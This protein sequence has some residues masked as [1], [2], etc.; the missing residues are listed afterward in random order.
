MTPPCQFTEGT[1]ATTP[2]STERPRAEERGGDSADFVHVHSVENVY[3]PTVDQGSTT[4]TTV[5]PSFTREH[6]RASDLWP[7][8]R[9]GRSGT[10]RTANTGEAACGVW[11]SCA[12]GCTFRHRTRTPRPAR[13][14]GQTGPSAVG[15]GCSRLRAEFL[16]GA[17]L[18]EILDPT[19]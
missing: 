6:T 17:K 16:A 11:D 19:L 1:G 10:R 2:P 8:C 5:R 13:G 4:L 9:I 7:E 14:E 12:S 3:S 18:R 15:R